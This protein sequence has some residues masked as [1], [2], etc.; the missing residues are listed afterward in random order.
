[1][2]EQVEVKK[3]PKSSKSRGKAKGRAAVKKEETK[4]PTTIKAEP[5]VEDI[6]RKRSFSDLNREYDEELEL[7]SEELARMEEEERLM[8][9]ENAEDPTL[10]TQE[11]SSGSEEPAQEAR[12]R[13]K[14]EPVKVEGGPV[15]NSWKCLAGVADGPGIAKTVQAVPDL[16]KP[17]FQV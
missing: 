3:E 13:R 12:G 11:A 7:V 15:K 9:L 2:P 14:V 17:S 5:A 16:K 4:G 1:V 8:R 10:A 6:G